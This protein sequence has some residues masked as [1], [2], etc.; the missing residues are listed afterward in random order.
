MAARATNTSCRSFVYRRHEYSIQQYILVIFCAVL[1]SVP[2]T[3]AF[4]LHGVVPS[5]RSSR[6]PL[7]HHS[8]SLRGH[9]N[10]MRPK[11]LTR[12][13]CIHNDAHGNEENAMMSNV[14]A[15]SDLSD[16]DLEKMLSAGKLTDMDEKLMTTELKEIKDQMIATLRRRRKLIKKLGEIS[17]GDLTTDFKGKIHTYCT[18]EE[19]NMT[20]AV[21]RLRVWSGGKANFVDDGRVLHVQPRANAEYPAGANSREGEGNVFVFPY[22]VVV[23]AVRHS[24]ERHKTVIEREMTERERERARN[25]GILQWP[26]LPSF[27]PS[28]T[29]AAAAPLL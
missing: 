17:S 8:C 11:L 18:A 19:Y 5:L 21:R 25:L 26:R 9:V 4:L 13:R 28:A 10:L 20:R 15:A 29:F 16:A 2:Y 3:T 12:R 27:V 22:G 23:R 7:A 6:P 1:V 24:A 14:T